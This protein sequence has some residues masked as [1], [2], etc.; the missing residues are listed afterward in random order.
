[1]YEPRAPAGEY[2]LGERAPLGVADLTAP[3]AVFGAPR[4]GAKETVTLVIGPSLIALGLSIGSGEWLLGPL[5]IG[6]VGWIGIGFVIM[7]SILLQA[8]T[9]WRSAAT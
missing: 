3:E 5:Q 7:L 2:P 6:T 1:M 9:T 4:I 8:F